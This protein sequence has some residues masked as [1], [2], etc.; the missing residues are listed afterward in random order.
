MRCSSPDCSQSGGRSAMML[1][2]YGVIYTVSYVVGHVKSTHM[3]LKSLNNN[4]NGVEKG[5]LGVWQVDLLHQRHQTLECGG[6]I[7]Q[8]VVGLELPFVCNVLESPSCG[9]TNNLVVEGVA[10][11]K[12]VLVDLVDNALLV[13]VDLDGDPL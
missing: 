13:L 4:A 11:I 1:F 5:H 2:A 7:W 8:E 12:Q 9:D 10:R 3:M 6:S